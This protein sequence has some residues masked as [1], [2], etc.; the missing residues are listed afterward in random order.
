MD[1]FSDVLRVVSFSG[2]VVF[3]ARC[4][5]PWAIESPAPRWLE[6]ALP[7]ASGYAIPFHAVV[8]G[9]ALVRGPTWEVTLAAGD[10]ILLPHA[11]AHTLRAGD[12]TAQNLGVLLAPP[13][14]TAVPEV[15]VGGSG[16]STRFLCGFFTCTGGVFN[17]LVRALPP[18][19]VARRGE[20]AAE[21]LRDACLRS[22]V[23]ELEA[24]RAGSPCVVGRLSELLFVEA[25][26]SHLA[27][28]GAE[29]AGWLA[30]LE[31]P[32]LASA[33]SRIHQEPMRAWTVDS[34]ARTS[35][36]SRSLFAAKFAAL[37]GDTPMHYV[38]R[39][40]MQ[41]AAS[42]LASTDES[43]AAI[44]DRHGYASEAAF[45]RAFRRFA[46]ATPAEWRRANR[47]SAPA[48]HGVVRPR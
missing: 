23:E 28:V 41:L 24:P 44:A 22:V 3:T 16:A 18:V 38:A 33:L 30:A 15:R 45:H 32:V 2:G 40:R 14:W 29:R 27:E 4:G 42:A 1:V 11:E 34:L 21:T 47:G 17:P 12:A 8:E 10:L 6:G 26:R 5:A 39:W 13:P 20:G 36:A 43:I 46:G 35:G 9:S 31:D 25:L 19:I 48:G 37:V 7:R